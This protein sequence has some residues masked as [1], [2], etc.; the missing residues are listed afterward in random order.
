MEMSKLSP[1][2]FR[3]SRPPVR[4]ELSV[5]TSESSSGA[6]WKLAGAAALSAVGLLATPAAA[7]S[8]QVKVMSLN[9]W[10]DCKDGVDGIAEMIRAGNPDVVADLM[11]SP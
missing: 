1:V 10:L 5:E 7:Q 8:A 9:V 6:N 4:P 3:A 2:K 11:V